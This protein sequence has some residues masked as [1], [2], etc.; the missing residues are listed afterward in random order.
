[1]KVNERRDRAAQGVLSLAEWTELA[2]DTSSQVR[3][4]VAGREDASPDALITLAADGI[5]SVREVVVE[6]PTCPGDA[7]ALLVC[8][9][10]PYISREAV[11]HRNTTTQTRASVAISGH[12]RARRA[13]A[14]LEDLHAGPSARLAVDN[15]WHVRE[16]LAWA[17]PHAEI[18]AQ[19]LRDAH[20]RVR[21]SLAHNPLTTD[22]QRRTL[23]QDP[24][25]ETRAILA[26]AEGNPDDVLFG[27]ARDKST[28][29]RFWLTVHGTN[30]PLMKLLMKDPSDMV[31]DTAR[32]SLRRPPR[33]DVVVIDR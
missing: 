4:A 31:A 16:E 29:V 19:L 13:L 20:P 14:Q 9:P 5:K 26:S 28:N 22:D 10:D 24:S 7:L 25:A 30:R 32:N 6:N 17:T 8:D 2:A 23:A 3:K 21:G 15:D 27:L 12:A 11:H 18:V 33:S 1:M